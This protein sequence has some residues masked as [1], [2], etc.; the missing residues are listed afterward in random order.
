MEAGLALESGDSEQALEIYTRLLQAPLELTLKHQVYLNRAICLYQ[1]GRYSDAMQQLQ[2]L[3][4]ESRDDALLAEANLYRARLYRQMGQY[5]SAKRYYLQ[6]LDVYAQDPEVSL[7]LFE[8]LISLNQDPEAVSMLE[9]ITEATPL[10]HEYLVI[11]A[12]Y[13]LTNYRYEEFERHL[14]QHPHLIG[15]PRID[16]LRLRKAF[17]T[18]DFSSAAAILDSYPSVNDQINYYK[19]LYARYQGDPIVADS[20]FAILVKKAEPEVKVLSYLQRLIM[21][22]E[23]EPFTAMLQLGQYISSGGSEV[24]KAEQY[25]TMGWFAYGRQDYQEALR[26]LSL[27]RAESQD[28]VQLAR[29][30]ILIAKAWLRANRAENAL[31]A[32]NRYLNLYP[33]GT[34]R[35]EALFYLGFLYF[36]AK[37]Y[38]L[39]RGAFEQLISETPQSLH[40]P[41]ANF[42]LA[43]MDFFL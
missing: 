43:E 39:A 38:N 35:D 22:Y 36:E 21:L 13:L 14:S 24:A 33:D 7:E 11:W 9:T 18:S 27:A 20:L 31:S 42:Y 8:T 28:K 30:D 5:F 17:S 15:E 1:Q 40:V 32:F 12:E 16:I 25:Y 4:S 10:Y 34:D 37:S 6:A 2:S 29:I 3:S 41:A 23:E 26:R 19:A